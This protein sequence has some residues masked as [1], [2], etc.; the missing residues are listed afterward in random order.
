MELISQHTKKIMEEC[1]VR[2]RD[3]GL[4]FGDETLE[5]IVTNKDMLELS[6]KVMIPTLY[7]YWV[8]DVEVLQKQGKY[9]LY[10]NNPY[11]TVI[12]SRPAISFYND[13]NPDWLNIMIFYH[14]L[15]HIDFF[16]NNIMFQDTWND[17][18][19]GKALAD[20]RMIANLR[21][22]QGR[23]VDYIIEFSRAIDNLVGYFGKMAS[24]AYYD[25]I[26]PTK[27]V[28]F[29]FDTFLQEIV[30]APEHEFFKEIERYNKLVSQ[31]KNVAE[32]LFFSEVRKKHPEFQAI[33][34]KQQDIVEHK[35]SDVIEFVMNNST[36]LNREKNLWMKSVISI[37]RNTSMYFQPQIRTKITNEGWASYWHDKL[38]RADNRIKG[39]E[40]AYSKIN[41]GVTSISRVGLNPYAIGLRLI[42]DIE[43]RANKGKL[44][45]NFQKISNIE[46]REK[47]NTNTNQGKDAIFNIR[48]NFSD[49]MLISTFVDQDFVDNHNLF[50]VGKRLDQQRG[51]YQYYVKSRKGYDYQKMLID[52][53]YHPPIIEVDVDKTSEDNLYLV[54]KFEGKQLIKDFIPETMVGIEFLWGGS[55]NVETTEIVSK[56]NNDGEQIF[57]NRKVLYTIK[58][59]KVT[60]HNL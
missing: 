35:H 22:E 41:A 9:K 3:A 42:Q 17:D 27:K 38:F 52:S 37:I 50:V 4:V 25:N 40:V 46:E 29:Y 39:N 26:N 32:S 11:E 54:H 34:E 6:P 51:V 47:F 45:Y 19:V 23:W 28:A 5:Y 44:S 12:N 18:F 55:V 60:K 8:H 24:Y 31:N 56:K 16:Q 10:P 43:D 59:R 7:D 49:F 30:K 53:L 58:D 48:S 20:K 21:T 1:K 33:F 2:A 36:F 14:V 15:G 13:N 57:E